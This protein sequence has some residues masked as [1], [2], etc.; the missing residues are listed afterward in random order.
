[1]LGCINDEQEP[2]LAD[3]LHPLLPY[4]MKLQ[5]GQARL[6]TKVDSLNNSIPDMHKRVSSLETDRNSVK[7]VAGAAGV[8]GG[9]IGWLFHLWVKVTS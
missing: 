3:D 7:A 9:F 2:T 6:E 1:M 5:D 8:A 4:I